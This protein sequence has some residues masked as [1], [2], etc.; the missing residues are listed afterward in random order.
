MSAAALKSI[1]FIAGLDI[2]FFYARK[3]KDAFFENL[4]LESH[5]SIAFVQLMKDSE[6]SNH[7]GI[8]RDDGKQ[9]LNCALY[10]RSLNL[11]YKIEQTLLSFTAIQV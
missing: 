10:V 2:E 11:T 9:K 5:N 4:I 7:S 1:C 3:L 6:R 8:R